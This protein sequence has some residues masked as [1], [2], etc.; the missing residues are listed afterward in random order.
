MLLSRSAGGGWS[1]VSANWICICR[2]CRPHRRQSKVLS[3]S[4]PAMRA[5]CTHCTGVLIACT[6]A[7]SLEVW[8]R[9]R[10]CALRRPRHT[11]RRWQRCRVARSSLCS[12]RWHSRQ[13]GQQQWQIWRVSE[14]VALLAMLAPWHSGSIPRCAICACR[15][16]HVSAC[17]QPVLHEMPDTVTLTCLSPHPCPL[18]CLQLRWRP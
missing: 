7:C 6:A 17:M 11:R 12:S 5:S 2:A 8:S 3:R 10:A 15:Q 9:S 4:N 16:R 13:R 14:L 1:L 18:W